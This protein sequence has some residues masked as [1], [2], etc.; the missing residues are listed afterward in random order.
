MIAAILLAIYVVVLCLTLACVWLSLGWT[1]GTRHDDG[2]LVVASACCF[3]WPLLLVIILFDA[4]ASRVER[5]RIAN[6][7]GDDR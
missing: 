1:F 3:G 6:R 5:K 2:A 7:C 4:W